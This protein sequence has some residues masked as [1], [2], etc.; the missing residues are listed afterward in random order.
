MHPLRR[1]PF[2]PQAPSLAKKA[3]T[4]NDPWSFESLRMAVLREQYVNGDMDAG[5]L[6][7]RL[8]LIGYVD[9]WLQAE[10]NY[11]EELKRK[12]VDK[13]LWRDKL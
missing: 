7:L 12:A 6:R 11:C 4:M 2:W 10:I 5:V 9:P 3:E 1:F 13:N 8:K